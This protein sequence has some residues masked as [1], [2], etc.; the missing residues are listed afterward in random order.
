MFQFIHPDESD[1]IYF[2]VI[3][4][5]TETQLKSC[6][7]TR[8]SIS[9]SLCLNQLQWRPNR[10]LMKFFPARTFLFLSE[11]PL[12]VLFFQWVCHER[13]PSHNPLMGLA[14]TFLETNIQH[15]TYE[16]PVLH[17]FIKLAKPDHQSPY[18]PF[19]NKRRST[20]YKL[21]S[22]WSK[23]NTDPN[24]TFLPKHSSQCTPVSQFIHNICKSI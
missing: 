13:S 18:E 3:S 9:L 24:H 14:V 2:P 5:W 8:V 1:H 4:H 21:M 17:T 10:S 19:W 20:M 11:S 15:Y 12:G 6:R 23:S 7:W 16:L 22:Y